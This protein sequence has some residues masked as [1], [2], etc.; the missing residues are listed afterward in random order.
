MYIFSRDTFFFLQIFSTHWFESAVVEPQLEGHTYSQG[1]L[2]TE[3]MQINRLD[4]L[5]KI[6]WLNASFRVAY[7]GSTACV[8]FVKHYTL[9]IRP[10]KEA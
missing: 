4:A 5:N 8:I 1:E 9:V 7:T 6:K 10:R 2:Q 3:F